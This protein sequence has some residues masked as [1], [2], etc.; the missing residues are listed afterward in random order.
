M[1]IDENGILHNF[2]GTISYDLPGRMSVK[3]GLL[4]ECLGDYFP[5]Q[6]QNVVLFL[7]EYSS[8]Q[9]EYHKLPVCYGG[10]IT[11]R[12]RE[13]NNGE[14]VLSAEQIEA[15]AEQLQKCHVEQKTEC[16]VNCDA[17]ME[18]YATLMCAMEEAA[19]GDYELVVSLSEPEEEL[20]DTS[21][22][23]EKSNLQKTNWLQYDVKNIKPVYLTIAV[24]IAAVIAGVLLGKHHKN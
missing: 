9:D 17:I 4:H 6:Y 12:I 8:V 13:F 15:I 10:G 21:V 3:E 11:Y 23:I 19:E 1:R 14:E 20:P 7:N 2:S 22:P 5:K 18:D 16:K 24:S